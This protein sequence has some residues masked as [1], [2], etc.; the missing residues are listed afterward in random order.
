MHVYICEYACIYVHV[1]T[2]MCV[3]IYVRVYACMY[4]YLFIY[5]FVYFMCMSVQSE[6]NIPVYICK[7][8]DE[9]YLL[10]ENPRQETGRWPE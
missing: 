10:W 9:L 6:Q 1:Y 4:V 2:S 7:K 5:L 8:C 3:C